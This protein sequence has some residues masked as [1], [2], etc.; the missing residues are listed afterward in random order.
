MIILITGGQRSGKS[1]YAENL[2]RDKENVGYIATSI[3][4]GKE[5]EER[6]KIHQMSRPQNWKTIETYKN[7]TQY[8]NDEDYY[9]LECVGTM[10]SNIMFEN[11][12]D[13]EFIDTVLS[14][15]IEDQIF[16][17]L[18]ELIDKV[19]EEDKTLVIVTN[20]VGFSLTSNNHLGRVYTDILGRINQK[21]AKLSDEA[22]LIVSG[23]EVRLK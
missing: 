23:M 1:T 20:E 22:Y 15:K 11:T 16:S 18:K 17:A 3:A 2:L 21:L 19:N 14:K 10:T 7:F 9:L 5:M 8:I 4:D 12:K 6:I 13:E